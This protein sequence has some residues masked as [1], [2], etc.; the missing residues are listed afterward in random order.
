MKRRAVIPGL[1]VVLAGPAVVA[2]RADVIDTF[3]NNVNLG[4][5]RLTSNPNRLYRIEETGGNP[6]AWLHGQVSTAVPTW[7]IDNPVGNPFLGDYAAEGI[8]SFRFDLTIS[9]G[10]QVPDRVLTLH[11]L[12]TLGTGQPSLGIEAYYLGQDISEYEP[13]WNTYAYP[14]DATSQTIPP[15]WVVFEGNGNPGTDAD[16]RS[17]VTHV[18]DVHMALGQ[19]GYAYPNLGIWDLGLDNV[20]LSTSPVPGPG[21]MTVLAAALPVIARRRRC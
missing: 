9:G 18:E 15:G 6:G 1:A 7:Y 16:W 10:I 13:G 8:H 3:D 21:A 14:L 4:T 17:L 12:T 20:D 11:L 5:W 2:A 19:P